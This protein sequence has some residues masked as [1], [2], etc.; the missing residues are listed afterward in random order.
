MKGVILI[1]SCNLEKDG[2]DW[3]KIV[4]WIKCDEEQD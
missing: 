3:F 2:G 4:F 1:A